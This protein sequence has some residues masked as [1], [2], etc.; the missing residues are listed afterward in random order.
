M[1]H[2]RISPGTKFRFKLTVLIFWTKF[3]QKGYLRSKSEKVNITTELGIFKL[4]EYKNILF[5]GA[6]ML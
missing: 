3:T 4:E 1:L 2:I 6:V 5:A